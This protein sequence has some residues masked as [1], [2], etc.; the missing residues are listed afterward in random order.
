VDAIPAMFSEKA[1]ICGASL[2]EGKWITKTCIIQEFSDWLRSYDNPTNY[3]EA[4][5]EFAVH[6]EMDM[7]AFVRA[8]A[9]LSVIDGLRFL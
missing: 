7:V 5:S 1:N 9:I 8:D 6:M 3:T 2:R 4:V